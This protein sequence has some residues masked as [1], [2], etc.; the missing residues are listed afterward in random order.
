MKKLLIIFCVMSVFF[1]SCVKTEKSVNASENTEQT[2]KNQNR[3]NR[4]KEKT[5]DFDSFKDITPEIYNHVQKITLDYEKPI[6][7]DTLSPEILCTLNDEDVITTSEVIEYTPELI[8]LKISTTSINEGYIIIQENPYENGKY[9]DAGTLLV[10]GKEIKLIKMPVQQYFVEGSKV[11]S[12]PREDSEV[13]YTTTWRENN[14]P[15]TVS[16][17]TE[18]PEGKP[19]WWKVCIEGKEG[20]I[21]SRNTDYKCPYFRLYDP[22]FIIESQ[23]LRYPH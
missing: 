3:R 6:Y 2:E 5:I 12:E 18:K 4:K 19:R 7:K 21:S 14:Q 17:I 13:I 1:S 23:V 22:E 11:M 9:S 15:I 10:D 8:Y 16:M 20:W